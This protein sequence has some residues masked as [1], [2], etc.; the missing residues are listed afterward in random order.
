MNS[1]PAFFLDTIPMSSPMSL[2]Y[3]DTAIQHYAQQRANVW[4]DTEPSTYFDELRE[5]VERKRTAALTFLATLC[6]AE[7]L[8]L[9]FLLLRVPT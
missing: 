8:A 2:I 5:R 6:L 1:P 9:A 4:A 7:S 3:T